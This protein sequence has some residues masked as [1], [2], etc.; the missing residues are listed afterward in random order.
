MKIPWYSLAACILGVVLIFALVAKNGQNQKSNQPFQPS[1]NPIFP[2][3]IP[4]ETEVSIA[5]PQP[6][7]ITNADRVRI[8]E[9]DI[10]APLTLREV[11]PNEQMPNPEGTDDVAIYDFSAF[12][13]M[14]GSP[15][16]GGTIVI[17]GHVDSASKPC[18]NGKTP[19][20]CQAVFWDLNKLRVGDTI[21]LF[22]NGVTH[23]YIVT[24]NQPVSAA[25]GPW[26]DIVS[27]GALNGEETLVAI[28][29][30]GDF[31]RDAREYVNRQ[32]V[33]AVRV[34]TDTA[35]DPS[36]TP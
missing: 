30:G 2:Q 13:G 32:V 22:V 20:P 33:T 24:A 19:P 3:G 4:E 23:V 21:E 16:N 25:N 28:T 14:G 34:N 9:F 15:G 27:I 7:G 5:F 6:A 36:P 18:N 29:C 26:P 35:P 10:D 8:G 1:A 11:I 31:D 17:A 12:P